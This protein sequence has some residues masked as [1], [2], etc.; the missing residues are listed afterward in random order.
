MKGIQ[1]A[2][3]GGSAMILLVL[4]LRCLLQNRLPRRLFPALW[5]AAAVRL[6]LPVAIPTRLSAWNLLQ[7]APA[8]PAG[9]VISGAAMPFPPFPQAAGES[10]VPAAGPVQISPVWLIWLVCAVL[11]GA[12]FV[13]GH[14]CM[15]RRFRAVRLVP[16]PS[17][18]AVLDHFRFSRTPRIC[19]SQS[20]RAP[21][22]FGVFRPTVLL[23]ENMDAQSEPFRLVL[24]H[25]LAH[26]RRKDCLRKL[27][28][29]VCL[30]LYWWNPLVWLMLRCANRDM[31]LACDEA[32]L[33]ALGPE[34]RKA[35]ALTLIEMARRGPKSAPLC[36]GFAKSGTEKRICA[37]LRFRRAPA[38]AGAAAAVFFVLSAG[39]FATQA[40]APIAASEPK[41]A[42]QEEMPGEAEPAPLQ[43]TPQMTPPEHGAAQNAAQEEP[44][45]A[46]AF[47]WPLE[48]AD[49][50]VTDAF[51]EREHPVSH[52][53]SIH[54]GVDLAAEMGS[55]VLAVADGTVVSCEY[56]EAYGYRLTLEHADGMRTRYAHLSKF[57]VNAG[58]PVRQGQIVAETGSTGWSTGPHLHLEVLLDGAY[59]DPM[60]ALK[61]EG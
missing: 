40:A 29:T 54:S 52:T 25:E 47:V 58:D 28:L 23:P 55:S 57:L 41:P 53:T 42:V 5:C 30:C 44:A 6:L 21:L 14:A 32:V 4:A 11:L 50:E 3:F 20:R 8:A 15:V 19:V 27:L 35:Y 33:C 34:C 45:D 51:G 16:Q 24:A 22:T 2:I 7:S 56:D 12:Y 36:S 48:N 38:W 26:I 59:A 39:V 31:E 60:Q 43:Q 18:Q 46:P 9:G 1:A 17:V 37:I 13:I 61:S 10:V 49:A